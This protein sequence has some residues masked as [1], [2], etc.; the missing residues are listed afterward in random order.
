M[1]DAWCRVAKGALLGLGVMLNV[2]WG[3]IIVSADGLVPSSFMDVPAAF[4]ARIDDRVRSLS[5]S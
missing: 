3:E 4:G 2:G 1:R 5:D